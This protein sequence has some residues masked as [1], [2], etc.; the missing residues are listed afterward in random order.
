MNVV[1]FDAVARLPAPADNVA[2]ATRTLPVDTRI[3]YGASVITLSHTVL[4]GHRF[5]VRPMAVGEALRSWEQTFGLAIRSIA[6]GDYVC[7]VDVPGG[8]AA[9]FVEH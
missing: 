2:I 8:V 7:N 9:P 3:Q 4:L 6:A 1:P 5:A